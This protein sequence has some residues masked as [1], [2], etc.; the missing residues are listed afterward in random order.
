MPEENHTI[1]LV[2]TLHNT[3]VTKPQIQYHLEEEAVAV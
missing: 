1:N 2:K 3:D